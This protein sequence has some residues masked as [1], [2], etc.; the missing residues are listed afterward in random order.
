MQSKQKGIAAF[1]TVERKIGQEA[2]TPTIPQPPPP[3][4]LFLLLASGLCSYFLFGRGEGGG[5]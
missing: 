2:F 3:P 1:L 4:P 5:G